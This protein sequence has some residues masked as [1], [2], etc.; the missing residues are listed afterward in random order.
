MICGRRGTGKSTGVKLAV[1]DGLHLIYV[2]RTKDAAS[3]MPDR[4][5][6]PA[7]RELFPEPEIVETGRR[8]QL[9]LGDGAIRALPIVDVKA[10]R[11]T[12][13]DV[14]GHEADGIVLDEAFVPGAAFVRSEPDLLVDLAGTIGRS[15]KT[16]PV[17][18][19][20]NPIS[21]ANPYSYAWRVNVLAEGLYHHNGRTTRVIGTAN[22]K[23]CFG[24]R[25][26][27]DAT[28]EVYADH[29]DRGGTVLT[30]NGRGLRIREIGG[31]MYAGCANAGDNVVMQRG[32]YTP[33]SLTSRVSR[34]IGLLGQAQ[35]EDRIVFDSFE[36]QMRLYELLRLKET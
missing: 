27:Q 35:L 16:P 22:C 12:G 3:S 31:W 6:P 19:I 23:D 34:F 36:A 20:G 26:G 25:I 29:L 4:I 2:Y 28:S 1:V 5:L 21:N 9:R 17:I 30:V 15:G 10:L 7:V 18:V 11:D 13:I 32:I 33:L 24:R 8:P 14:D